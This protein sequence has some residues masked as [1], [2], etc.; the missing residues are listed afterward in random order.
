MDNKLIYIYIY[1]TH[2]SYPILIFI[3]QHAILL[4]FFLCN[5]QLHVLKINVSNIIKQDVAIQFLWM[6]ELKAAMI[7]SS[8][9]IN[10]RNIKV[11][12]GAKKKVNYWNLA[13]V[14][15]Q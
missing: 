2:I 11:R 4:K 7:L 5:L 10:P 1:I 12:T 3:T 9:Q 13:A 8:C 14:S 6:I 15:R